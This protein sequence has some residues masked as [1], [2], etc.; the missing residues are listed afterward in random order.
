METESG[1]LVNGRYRIVR[2]LG[3]GGMGK[4]ALARD[5]AEGGK[6]IALK[7]VPRT[8]GRDDLTHMQH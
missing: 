2:T 8:P 5:L 4:V 7:S 1:E 3:R 6:E